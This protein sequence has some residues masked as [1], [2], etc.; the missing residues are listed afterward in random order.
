MSG[1]CGQ[2]LVIS[3][4]LNRLRVLIS[5][6]HFAATLTVSAFVTPKLRP[7]KPV[8]VGIT[9]VVLLPFHLLMILGAAV[10]N[11]PLIA[12]F[13]LPIFVMGFPRPARFWP[14]LEFVTG[15]VAADSESGFYK[16]IWPGLRMRLVR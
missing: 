2:L 4:L 5:T 16:Q 13:G 12:V 10:L 9:A 14:S 8:A 15:P 7:R 3:F 11:A 6:I 1:F